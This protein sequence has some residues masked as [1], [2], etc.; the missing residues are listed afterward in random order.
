MSKISSKSP[1]ETI[2]AITD[3]LAKHHNTPNLH[4]M[5]VIGDHENTTTVVLACPDWIHTAVHNIVI[6]T[7]N[8]IQPK[9]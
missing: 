9:N 8:E 7:I 6:D 5:F 3:L 2:N 1:E 4:V